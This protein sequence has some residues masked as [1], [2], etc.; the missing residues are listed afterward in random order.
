MCEIIQ[1]SETSTAFMCGGQPT[2]HTCNEDGLVLILSD[3]EEVPD[4]PDNQVKYEKEI[5]GGSVCCTVCG[6]SAFSNAMWLDI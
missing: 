5:R 1:L 2:D 3:E 4:T 6:R